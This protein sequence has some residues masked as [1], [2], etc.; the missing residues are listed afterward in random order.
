MEKIN[1]VLLDESDKDREKLTVLLNEFDFVNV[2]GNTNNPKDALRLID[3]LEPQ[4]LFLGIKA[5]NI[6]AFKL[7]EKVKKQ[8]TIVFSTDHTET[9]KTFE[10]ASLRYVKKPYSLDSLQQLLISYQETHQQLAIKMQGL[11]NKLK[12]DD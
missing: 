11:L 5:D 9:I 4:L 10:A 2:V 6:D 12:F 1:V 3:A 8:P 7:L